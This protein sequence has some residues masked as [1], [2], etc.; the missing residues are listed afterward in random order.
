MD[1]YGPRPLGVSG[2]A[3]Y[4]GPEGWGLWKDCGR[5]PSGA[6]LCAGQAQ[7]ARDQ[8]VGANKHPVSLLRGSAGP[9]GHEMS[10]RCLPW[11]SGRRFLLPQGAHAWTCPFWPRACPTV[12][13]TTSASLLNMQSR[14]SG[15]K[16]ATAFTRSSSRQ[17]HVLGSVAPAMPT[18]RSAVPGCPPRPAARPGLHRGAGWDPCR[19]A[20]HTVLPEP[21]Q[22]VR[23]GVPLQPS[24]PDGQS[25]PRG[26]ALGPGGSGRTQLALSELCLLEP[27]SHL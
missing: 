4:R 26:L 3:G 9:G 2:P 11:A 22:A 21:G 6:G 23:P 5:W 12:P 20:A 24:C 19:L 25:Q 14:A 16:D 1:V 15:G 8:G 27:Q 17:S 7:K 13:V 18:G 10:R